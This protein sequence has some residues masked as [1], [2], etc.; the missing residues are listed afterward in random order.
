MTLV[1]ALLGRTVVLSLALSLI[2]CTPVRPDPVT[3]E[4]IARE[5]VTDAE[6]S[7]QR[8]D[9]QR[10]ADQIML[11]LHRAPVVADPLVKGL[12]DRYPMAAVCY[13]AYFEK[14]IA[15]VQE[16]TDPAFLG[17]RLRAAKRADLFS[18]ATIERL[19]TSYNDRMRQIKQIWVDLANAEANAVFGCDDKQHCEKAFA[20]TQIYINQTSDMKLQVTTDSIIETFNPTKDGNIGLKAI[21][22]PGSGSTATI[23]LSALC[24]AD[25]SEAFRRLCAQRKLNAY[26]GYQ[27]YMQGALQ[28]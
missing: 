9:C 8:N 13:E 27:A 15:E 25:D 23:R 3:P 28:R 5:Y 7:M 22:T 10:G 12:F 2:A 6:A 1:S 14:G 16:N 21:K 4:D 19:L 11:A 20:L 24:R 26:L 18:S 17:E